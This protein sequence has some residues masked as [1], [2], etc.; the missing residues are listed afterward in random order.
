MSRAHEESRFILFRALMGEQPT[1]TPAALAEAKIDLT[2]DADACAALDEL[3]DV[4]VAVE[5]TPNNEWRTQLQAYAA[6]QLSGQVDQA[7]FV[8][9]RQALDRSVPLAEEYALLFETMQRER[10]ATLPTP[11][12]IPLPRLDFLPSSVCPPKTEQRRPFLQRGLHRLGLVAGLPLRLPTPLLG[13][14]AQTASL[15]ALVAVLAGGVWWVAQPTASQAPPNNILA[16]P[17]RTE[18]RGFFDQQMQQE[19][20]PAPAM[21]K[22]ADP[23]GSA[24]DACTDQRQTGLTRKECPL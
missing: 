24:P 14:L 5:P 11:S 2:N 17:T 18:K 9:V 15:L 16:T 20:L 12:V 1:P 23:A 10:Q 13:R 22:H 4:I 21:V 6:A 3:L 7:E 8:G 19:G